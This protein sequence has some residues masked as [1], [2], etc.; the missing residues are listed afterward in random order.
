MG[1]SGSYVHDIMERYGL[2]GIHVFPFD[3]IYMHTHRYV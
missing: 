3:V 1:Y 2:Q